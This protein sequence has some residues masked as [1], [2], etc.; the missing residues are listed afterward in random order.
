ME[1]LRLQSGLDP[2]HHA[3]AKLGVELYGDA[4]IFRN[5]SE[6][7]HGKDTLGDALKKVE[8]KV[9]PF[10]SSAGPLWVQ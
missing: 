8:A 6:A 1:P 4:H 2:L 5:R 7:P 3:I 9:A 10:T